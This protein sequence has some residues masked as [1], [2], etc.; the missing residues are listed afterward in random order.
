MHKKFAL[1]FSAVNK[2]FMNGPAHL[3][4]PQSICQSFC[5]TFFTMFL[6]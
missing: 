3:S 5:H 1:I 6:L 4:V 2:Q